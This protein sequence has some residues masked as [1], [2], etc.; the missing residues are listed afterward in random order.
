MKKLVFLVGVSLI[1]FFAIKGNGVGTNGV[2]PVKTIKKVKLFKVGD[3]VRLR[4]GG[5]IMTV[6]EVLLN[7]K[8]RCS[9]IN[10]RQEFETKDFDI[11]ELEWVDI[12]IPA[13]FIINDN[14]ITGK[15]FKT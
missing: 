14:E 8:L 11:N 3:D 15:I 12:K 6:E 5:P 7:N 2:L 13:E 10:R 1:S 9:F 4:S